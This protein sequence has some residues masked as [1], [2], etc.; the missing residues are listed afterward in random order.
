[1]ILNGRGEAFSE[2]TRARVTEAARTLRYRPQAAGRMLVNG[3]TDA[4]GVMVCHGDLLAFDG[5]VPQVLHA[6]TRASHEQGYRIMLEVLE[7]EQPE[8]ERPGAYRDLIESRQIDGLLVIDPP[9]NDERLRAL[10]D[11]EVPMVLLGTVGHRGE[12]SVNVL[13]HDAMESLVAHLYERGHRRFGFV[14]A[15][16]RGF[17]S[18]DR[19]LEGLRAALGRRG[20][21]LDADCVAF[22]HYS[23]ESGYEA[24]RSLFAKVRP[25]PTALL[26][27][28]D[29]IALGV[30]RAVAEAGLRVPEDLAVTGFDNLPWSAFL[31]TPLTSVDTFAARQGRTA[32][33]LLV[34]RLSGRVADGKDAT[35]A[36]ELI[37]RASTT[38]AS[39]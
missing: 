14:T 39:A 26:G 30:L 7:S 38:Y 17:G 35:V 24:T 9:E 5:F 1:M 22:G 37:V 13:T 20:L 6:V 21:S 10:L 18:A 2:S 29:T 3:R 11:A 28:N 15:S 33:Q 4:I 16:P 8:N 23:A 36:T 19:R 31:P 12:R 27:G 34:E 25:R 32:L